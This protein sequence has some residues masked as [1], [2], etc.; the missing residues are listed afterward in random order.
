MQHTV[1]SKIKKTPEDNLF[2]RSLGPS[3]RSHSPPQNKEINENMQAKEKIKISP[4]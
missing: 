2:H 3:P 1:A 4:K